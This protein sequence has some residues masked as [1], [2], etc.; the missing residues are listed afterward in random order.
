[1]ATVYNDYLHASAQD[2][3]KIGSLLITMPLLRLQLSADYNNNNY[4]FGII[5]TFGIVTFIT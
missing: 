3:C 2:E 4:Y 1:M 5:I